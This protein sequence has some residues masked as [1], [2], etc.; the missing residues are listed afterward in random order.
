M[1]IL[2]GPIILSVVI[3]CLLEVPAF[4]NGYKGACTNVLGRAIKLNIAEV[5]C[6]QS[7]SVIF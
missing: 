4:P 7:P 1:C 5:I 3:I 2:L 6:E